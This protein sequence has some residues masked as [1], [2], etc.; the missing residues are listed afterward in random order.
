MKSV[1]MIAAGLLLAHSVTLFAEDAKTV[2]PTGTW[3]WESDNNGE[4]VEHSLTLTKNDKNEVVGVYN[5]MLDNLKSVK[6]SLNG[7][8]LRLFF[9]VD[10]DGYTFDAEYD[11]TFNG[12]RGVGTLMLSSDQGEM[13]IPWD[14]KRSV[15]LSDLVGIWN[16]AIETDE[17]TAKP[18]L[19]IAKTGDKYNVE[20]ESDRLRDAVVSDLKTD[21]SMISFKLKGKID[22]ADCD[23]NCTARPRGDSLSGELSLTMGDFDIDLPVKGTRASKKVGLAGVVGK[24]VLVVTSTEQ[25]MKSAIVIKEE[26]G[27]FS[28]IYDANELGQFPVKDLKMKGDRLTFTFKGTVQDTEFFADANLKVNGNEAKGAMELEIGDNFVDLDLAGKRD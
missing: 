10:T 5:G 25:E 13:E 9:E 12:D 1:C 26:D 2:D 16:L 8:K 18:K 3:R 28:A 24:W 22:G 11:V 19:I 15:E 4:T 23:A 27:K 14:A 17:G 20:F 7:N 21:G 6:G